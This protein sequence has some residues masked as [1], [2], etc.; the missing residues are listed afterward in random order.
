MHIVLMSYIHIWNCYQRRYHIQFSSHDISIHHSKEAYQTFKW[1]TQV[2]KLSKIIA[3]FGHSFKQNSTVFLPKCKVHIT[4]PFVKF[5]QTSVISFEFSFVGL[6]SMSLFFGRRMEFVDWLFPMSLVLWRRK[7]PERIVTK[8]HSSVIICVAVWWSQSCISQK[9]NCQVWNYSFI[10]LGLSE[11]VVALEYSK[12][13]LLL[14]DWYTSIHTFKESEQHNRWNKQ[15][16]KSRIC[17]H[18]GYSI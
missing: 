3:L 5:L 15:S 6:L 13:A 4:Q 1:F 16:R 7:V 18:F 17:L 14:D 10:L 8:P 9:H 2:N 11:N 12:H